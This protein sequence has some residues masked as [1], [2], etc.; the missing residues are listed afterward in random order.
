MRALNDDTCQN[1]F[2]G[3]E[4]LVMSCMN[5]CDCA[6]RTATNLPLQVKM[7][8]DADFAQCRATVDNIWPFVRFLTY[9]IQHGGHQ[10]NR[11]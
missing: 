6:E 9:E 10:V 2:K 11:S 8:V 4:Q 3:S 5:G 1:S 7:M